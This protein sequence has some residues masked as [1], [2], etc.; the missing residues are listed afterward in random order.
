MDKLKGLSNKKNCSLCTISFF[1][2]FFQLIYIALV[3][4]LF[5]K[6]NELFGRVPNYIGPVMFLLLF[7]ASALISALII[8]GYPFYLFWEEK[9]TKKAL[10]LVAYT[11]VWLI[12]FLLMILFFLVVLR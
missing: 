10:K 5:W 2:A 4:I 8:L 6:G 1:Q 9:K 3:A 11:T 12:F 7:V